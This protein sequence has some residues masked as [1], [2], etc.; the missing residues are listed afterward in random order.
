MSGPDD[1]VAQTVPEEASPAPTPPRVSVVVP[2][3]NDVARLRLCLEALARQS[4]PAD[5]Y[6]VLVVDNASTEDVTAAVPA[7]ARFRLL[8][9]ERPGSYAARNTGLAATDAEVVA[10]TD[11]DCLPM[12]DWLEAGVGALTADTTVDAVGGRIELTFRSG[13]P[14]SPAE[15]FEAV[16][17]FPQ[18]RYVREMSFAA[19]ANLF[20]RRAA[21]DRVGSFDERLRSGGD[22]DFGKRLTGAG[23]RLVYDAA[24]VVQHPARH[25]WAQLRAKTVRVSRGV[26]DRTGSGDRARTVRRAGRDLRSAAT[27]WLRVWLMPQPD[28]AV[29]KL[30]YAAA[31]SY[32]RLLRVRT[33]VWRDV[34]AAARR[35]LRRGHR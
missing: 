22:V 15:H 13:R 20:V 24:P 23:G 27:V 1:R 12:D 32:V 29:G 10:F 5:R 35:R 6:D 26:S 25:T 8:R 4:Y 17:G 33:Y 30:A 16:G 14:V 31:F 7:D 28:Q 19:T 11:S 9:E 3:Y 34:S 2:V 18:E 21:L